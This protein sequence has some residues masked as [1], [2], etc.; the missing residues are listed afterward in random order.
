VK[1]SAFSHCGSLLAAVSGDGKIVTLYNMGTMT[2]VRQ[3]ALPGN[4][5]LGHWN[6]LAF[7]PDGKTQVFR[8]DTDVIHICEVDDLNIMRR[9]LPDAA[10]ERGSI[11]AVALDPSGQFLASFG[12]DQ[13][14]RLW[15]LYLS[16][17]SLYYYCKS[18]TKRRAR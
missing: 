7:S 12:G 15:T 16:R 10:S 5:F 8:F 3:L 17:C 13:N 1:A 14:V 2:V 6:S 4:M 18:L 9:L 11:G